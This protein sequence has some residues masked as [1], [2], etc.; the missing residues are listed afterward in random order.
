MKYEY[1]V[2]YSYSK[3]IGRIQ[4]IRD[5]K[6][7]SYEQVESTDEAIRKH[8]DLENIFIVDFKLLRTYKE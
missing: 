6:I 1:M 4:I 5:R 3:G 2:V 8:I 7:D